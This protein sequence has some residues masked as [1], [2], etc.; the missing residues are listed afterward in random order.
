MIALWLRMWTY[1]GLG[2]GEVCGKVSVGGFVQFEV[3]WCWAEMVV[4]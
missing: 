4:G 3:R 1:S 2:M